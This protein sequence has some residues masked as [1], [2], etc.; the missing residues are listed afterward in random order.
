MLAV[1]LFFVTYFRIYVM[2]VV[3]VGDVAY[4][5]RSIQWFGPCIV[6]A[7]RVFH[8]LSGSSSSSPSATTQ[9][10]RRPYPNS[11][12]IHDA[13]EGSRRTQNENSLKAN[14]QQSLYSGLFIHAPFRCRIFTTFCAVPSHC[15]SLLIMGW[16]MTVGHAAGNYNIPPTWNLFGSL[17]GYYTLERM[18]L[19]V[20]TFPYL[21]TT[22]QH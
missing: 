18:W 13:F 17:V 2:N 22:A 21:S 3:V 1:L 4:G 14:A 20:T 12:P 10:T 5:M 16:R 15:G 6:H 8:F 11:E 9:Q 7:W 19:E